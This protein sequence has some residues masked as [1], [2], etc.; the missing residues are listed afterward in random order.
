MSYLSEF[1]DYDGEFFIPKEWIDNSWH[2]DVCPRAMF[3]TEIKKQ[4]V[5]CSLWQDYV[6][7]GKREYDNQKRY[8]FQIHVDN[9]LVFHYESDD[10]EEMKKLTE[11]VQTWTTNT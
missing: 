3:R 1:P 6:D 9:E 7:E 2:N 5:E 11:G 4:T 8:L 10:L